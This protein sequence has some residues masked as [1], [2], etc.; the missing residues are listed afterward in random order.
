MLGVIG[1]ILALVLGLGV[2]YFMAMNPAPVAVH[3][4]PGM[5]TRSAFI[6]EIALYSA[7]TGVLI[8]ACLLLWGW[9]G[10]HARCRR[11][12]RRLR[13]LE[14]KLNQGQPL[15]VEAPRAALEKRSLLKAR[16]KETRAVAAPDEEPV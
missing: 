11:L 9:L 6:S 14:A 10:A 2:I 3:L 12:A 15:V 1:A 16:S 5:P 8:G 4:W 7:L 13:E